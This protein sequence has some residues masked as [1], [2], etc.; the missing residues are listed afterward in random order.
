[1]NKDNLN[2]QARVK[3][4][5]I[6]SIIKKV[7]EK[8]KNQAPGKIWICRKGN[9]YQYFSVTKKSKN[10]NI[11]RSYIRKSE[12]GKIKRLLQN[13]YLTKALLVLKK[14]E[15]AL[16]QFVKYYDC[17]KIINLYE[18]LPQGKK[19]HVIPFIYDDEAF[20]RKWQSQI[21]ERKTVEKSD[22]ITARNEK[23]R[24]KSE[25]I[26][27][28]L[29]QQKNVPYHYEFPLKLKNGL[30]I[31]P[32]FYCLNKR[33]QESFYWEHFGMMT[34]REYAANF[35]QRL[36]LFSQNNIF[37]GRNLLITTESDSK[38]LSTKD[39][40]RLIDNFLT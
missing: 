4:M 13:E 23:V 17:Q 35:V 27:A 28:N 11:K 16:K 29:L 22:F 31:H 40:E 21:F 30:V 24:S 36:S 37:P 14:S 3:V 9:S 26:I 1:M 39:I 6:E 20:A 8:L 34:D 5:E 33:T 15:K 2:Q 25:H 18:R 32:D 38:P 10:G 19:N 7:E 12:Q